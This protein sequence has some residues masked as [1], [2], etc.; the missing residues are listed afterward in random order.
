VEAH[1]E[2]PEQH[3]KG[4][5]VLILLEIQ[6]NATS[7]SSKEKRSPQHGSSQALYGASPGQFV[8]RTGGSLG[9][10]GQPDVPPEYL[11]LLQQ[12]AAQ[13]QQEES[14]QPPSQPVLQQLLI[15]RYSTH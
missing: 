8:V 14:A 6:S 9:E 2:G 4:D 1:H 13:Q 15:S 5:K 7:S 3:R 12:L 11:S 10:N